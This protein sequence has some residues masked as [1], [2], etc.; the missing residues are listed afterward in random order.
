MSVAIR[1]AKPDWVGVPLF[2][3]K[4][5]GAGMQMPLTAA[6]NGSIALNKLEN[7]PAII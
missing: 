3:V 5:I 6:A 2:K 1:I 4:C 7:L